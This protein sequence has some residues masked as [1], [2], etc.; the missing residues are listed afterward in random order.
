VCLHGFVRVY[1]S[2]NSKDEPLPDPGLT[3]SSNPR[4]SQYF[5]NGHAS[6]FQDEQTLCGEGRLDIGVYEFNFELEFPK[7]G[8]PTSLDVSYIP[9][10]AECTDRPIV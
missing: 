4:K 6:L 2:A 3:A 1:K 5:G 8:V 10:F 9:H 7:K